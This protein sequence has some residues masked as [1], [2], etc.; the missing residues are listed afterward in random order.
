MIIGGEDVKNRIR[1]L[2]ARHKM[3][4]GELASAAGLSRSSIS[5]IEN[6]EQVPAGD[7]MIRIAKVL[8]ESVEYTF[9]NMED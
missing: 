9:Y 6:G 1:E 2:R 4:Q 3:S 5:N 8:G 7:A